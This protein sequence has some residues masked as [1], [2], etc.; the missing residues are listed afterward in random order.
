MATSPIHTS[1]AL[2]QARRGNTPLAED[3]PD[4]EAKAMMPRFADDMIAC[5]DEPRNGETPNVSDWATTCGRFSAR[6]ANARKWLSLSKRKITVQD[7]ET[8]IASPCRLIRFLRRPLPG[9]HR[10]TSGSN[11]LR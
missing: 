4:L 3:M 1:R 9:Q 11:A 2:A 6:S 10:N 8:V 5:R 7:T